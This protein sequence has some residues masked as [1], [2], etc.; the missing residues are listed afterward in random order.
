[1]KSA[2][3]LSLFAILAVSAAFAQVT[4]DFN[5]TVTCNYI[6]FQLKE[7]DNV[8]NYI[9]W[10]IGNVN[11]GETVEMTTGS[12]G[13]HV[14]V[15]NESN[16][17]LDFNAYSESP[18]PTACGYGTETAWGPAAAAG[19]DAYLLE[20][21]KGE[22]ATVP[23]AYTTIT[24]TTIGGANNYY[25]TAAGESYHLYTQLTTPTTSTDGCQHDIT[26]YI[27]AVTP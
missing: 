2:V 11:E 23:V 1:M 4:D 24:A 19:L 10:P 15:N 14:Y 26:V 9:T 20:L 8:A 18:T 3:I 6:Q 16:L 5:I 25:T 27:V 22:E 12:G 17:A 7:A 13:D 21:G